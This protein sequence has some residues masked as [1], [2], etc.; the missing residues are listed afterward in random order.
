[1]L[2][3]LLSDSSYIQKGDFKYEDSNQT[4]DIWN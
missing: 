3:F 4:W 1:M 2:S